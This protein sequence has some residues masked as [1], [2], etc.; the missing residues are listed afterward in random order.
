[1]NTPLKAPD[2]PA[3]PSASRAGERTRS[4][5]FEILPIAKCTPISDIMERDVAWVQPSTTTHQLVRL[6]FARDVSGAPVLDAYHRPIGMVSKT[7][8]L[9]SIARAP[10]EQRAADV[11]TP[12]PLSLPED[13]SIAQASAVMAY[14]HVHRVMV[15]GA[16]GSLVGLVSTIDVL[17]W[18]AR[19]VGYALP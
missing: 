14:E 15:I 7:D 16:D 19:E 5:E 12:V 18:L 2:R 10:N 6:F 17:R 11:M 1:M 13:A 4:G 3:R 9:R 8:V